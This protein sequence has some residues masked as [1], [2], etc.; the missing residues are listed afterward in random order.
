MASQS[1]DLALVEQ[2]VCCSPQSQ[3]TAVLYTAVVPATPTVDDAIQLHKANRAFL[4]K[5][6]RMLAQAAALAGRLAGRSSRSVTA[7]R[8]MK[9]QGITHVPTESL[10]LPA[11]FQQRKTYSRKGKALW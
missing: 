9:K 11:T 6:S 3:G 1:M 5:R 4:V 10:H 2:Q 8:K 7:L